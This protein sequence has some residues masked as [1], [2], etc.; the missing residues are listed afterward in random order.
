MIAKQ[1]AT[2]D[3]QQGVPKH[4]S[5]LAPGVAGALHMRDGVRP[6][7]PANSV[8]AASPN[9]NAGSCETAHAWRRGACAPPHTRGAAQ[10]QHPLGG[11][12]AQPMHGGPWAL[13]ATE[14]GHSS[15]AAMPKAGVAGA[16]PMRG[17]TWGVSPHQLPSS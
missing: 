9:A 14:R 16:Q 15:L 3:R 2:C 1:Q 7:L 8:G 4:S 12:G 11:A 10:P 6:V 5:E 17:G 13:P